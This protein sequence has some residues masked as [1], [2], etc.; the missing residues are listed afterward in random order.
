MNSTEHAQLW[1]QLTV[2][3]VKDHSYEG[4]TYLISPAAEVTMHLSRLIFIPFEENL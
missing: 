2:N 1:C 4:L 3:P